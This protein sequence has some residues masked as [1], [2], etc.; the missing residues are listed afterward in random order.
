MRNR[1][2]WS[3]VGLFLVLLLLGGTVSADTNVVTAA[4][5]QGWNIV[6]GAGTNV[7]GFSGFVSS[8]LFPPPLGTGAYR[9]RIEDANQK[10]VLGR[11]DLNGYLL[12]DITEFSY[13]VIALGT[14]VQPYYANIYLNADA[15]P[16]HELRLDT[17]L[18]AL[19][20]FTWTTIDGMT[21]QY[22]VSTR[23]GYVYSGP[24]PG[25]LAQIAAAEPNATIVDAF[26][27]PGN[28]GFRLNM[29]DTASSY[30]GFDGLIDNVRLT[31]NGYGSEVWDFE[32]LG[33]V[34]QAA[35]GQF[36]S[37]PTGTGFAAE[38]VALVTDSGG[39]PIANIPV[40][41]TAPTS[42]AS[43]SFSGPISTV[44]VL[45]DASG[46]AMSGAL[47][48]NS[49]AGTYW[50]TATIANDPTVPG[51]FYPLT[52]TGSAVTPVETELVTNGS[53]EI[54]DTGQSSGVADWKLATGGKGVQD[55]TIATDGACSYRLKGNN[56]SILKQKITSPPIAPGDLLR[57][58]ASVQGKNVVPALVSAVAQIKYI[59]G[60][61]F[62]ALLLIPAGTFPFAHL[63][64]SLGV[65]GD[66]NKVI[67][68]LTVKAGGGKVW[69]DEVSAIVVEDG[70]RDARQADGVLPAPPAPTGWR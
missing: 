1:P 52:N 9:V 46:I 56:A 40:T 64:S 26:G 32:E 11:F 18:P 22:L 51:V 10:T 54:A 57:F 31:V 19:T 2:I 53:F 20:P 12:A 50:V 48:A 63:E 65:F 55:C 24:N 49:I 7:P 59:N 37:T 25:T 3:L 61:K 66:V 14:N 41:F 23:G 29:G 45:T 39:S 47:T 44:T 33:S 17:N 16:D 43:A 68:K 15:D 8:P 4:N 42:G 34:L 27:Q 28:P 62:K 58:S 13:D 70:L 69:F 60:L 35:G 5:P 21:A 30:V 67:V 38:L 36:Q 6:P